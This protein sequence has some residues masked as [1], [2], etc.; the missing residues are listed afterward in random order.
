MSN[1][2]QNY[3]ATSSGGTLT[4]GPSHTIDGGGS[5]HA[6]LVNNG[7]VNA[8]FANPLRLRT[9]TKTNNGTVS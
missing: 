1:N 8:T 7:T 9:G 4:Q 3:I 2:P 5:L 6:N